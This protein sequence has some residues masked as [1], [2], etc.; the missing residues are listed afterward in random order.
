MSEEINFYLRKEKNGWLSNFWRSEIHI[1]KDGLCYFY[2]SNEHQ[3]QAEK[4]SNY[5]I[6]EWI[7]KAPNPY[8][9]MMAGRALRKGKELRDDW[10][11]VKVSLMK[12]CLMNKFTQNNTLRQL[13]INT[14]DAIIHED[15]ETDMFWGK[16]GKDML[17][18]LLMQVRE[19]LI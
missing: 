3:Y 8:L 2:D 14:G 11:E 13:L 16:K 19:E 1:D 10:E 7:R 5:A 15:S 18:K 6:S 9:A 12:K 4:G 17:G